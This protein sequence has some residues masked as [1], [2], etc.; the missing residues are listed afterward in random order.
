MDVKWYLILVL[1]CISLMIGDT[2]RYWPFFI[3]SLEEMSIQV[4][5]HLGQVW[6]LMPVNLSYSGS[7]DWKDQGSSPAEAKN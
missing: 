7:I 4:V 1:I 3:S 6:W 2:E 5:P